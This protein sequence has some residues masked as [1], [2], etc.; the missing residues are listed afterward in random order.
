MLEPM[1]IVK[2]FNGMSEQMT[3]IERDAFSAQENAP[4]AQTRAENFN[5]ERLL[6]D[7]QEQTE[8]FVTS[9]SERA[10]ELLQRVNDLSGDEL[11]ELGVALLYGLGVDCDEKRAFE[12]LATAAEQ[13]S[14]LGVFYLGICYVDAVGT[15]CDCQRGT[16]LLKACADKGNAQAMKNLAM[17]YASG[18]LGVEDFQQA[19]EWMTRAAF[20]GD[21]EA[22][23]VALQQ[24]LWE[25]VTR[26]LDKG[27]A[28]AHDAVKRG[29]CDAAFQLAICYAQG[30][31]VPKDYQRAC[32]L[33][34]TSSEQGDPTG[35]LEM[36]K[37]AM[38][39]ER[40]QDAVEPCQ[41]AMQLGS[42]QAEELWTQIQPLIESAREPQ[43]SEQGEKDEE[44]DAQSYVGVELQSAANVEETV[45]AQ[46]TLETPSAN[47]SHEQSD[48]GDD[49]Q[50]HAALASTAVQTVA[51][52]DLSGVAASNES[53]ASDSTTTT[54]AACE[55]QTE[56]T[57]AASTRGGLVGFFKSIFKR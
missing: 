54:E 18:R 35:L 10:P 8:E 14:Q 56:E 21:A 42:T 27:V 19:C 9:V 37:L 17:I 7:C 20:E 52:E 45:P 11:A 53:D 13:S 55:S 50:V 40:L 4:S 24:L 16:A 26:D 12:L 34:E 25:D 32:Q 46:A 1:M 51:E 36:A 33:Y 43:A 15:A 57:S 3:S 30:L 28:L 44:E 22:T 23:G 48:C 2:G 47:Q 6:L 41:K 38:E 29:D 5:G 49:A 31:G 39:N